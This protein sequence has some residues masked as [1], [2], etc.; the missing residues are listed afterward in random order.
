MIRPNVIRFITRTRLARALLLIPLALAALP[1]AVPTYAATINLNDASSCAAVGGGWYSGP[2]CRFYGS[3]SLNVA[4]GDVLNVSVGVATGYLTNNGTINLTNGVFLWTFGSATNNGTINLASGTSINNMQGTFTNNGTITVPCGASVAGTISGNAPQTA[5]DC[6]PPKASPTQSPAA[7]A[8]GWNNTDVT[9][10]W[11][12]SDTGGPGIDTANC[13]ASSTSSGEGTIKLTATCA[14]VKGLQGSANYT[15]QVDKTP[16]TISAAATT[17]ANAN[18]WYNGNVTVHFTCND[19]LSGI[20]N[21][22][23]PSDQVLSAEGAS[24]SSTP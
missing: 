12:W 16:P 2:S 10:N 22:A 18:G 20:P 7:N 17:P 23:C 19:A 11:N 9:V 6:T 14:D 3:A 24:V 4:A 1:A 15:V 5:T 21:G 13:P 8:A